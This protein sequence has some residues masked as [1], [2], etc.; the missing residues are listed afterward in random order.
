MYIAPI[1]RESEQVVDYYET[2]EFNYID[3]EDVYTRKYRIIYSN[4]LNGYNL[5]RV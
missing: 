2:E 3:G 1:F 5:V 4:R